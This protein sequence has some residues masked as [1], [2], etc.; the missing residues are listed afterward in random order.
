MLLATDIGNTNISFG[1]FKGNRLK[2]TFDIPTKQYSRNKLF[3]K[4]IPL[5]PADI[6]ISSVVPRM[7]RV[8]TRDL[9]EIAGKKPYIIGKDTKVPIKNLY[10]KPGQV[11][12]DRLV[13][14]YAALKIYGSPLVIIDF[15]TAITFDIISKSGAYEGGL[16]L[17]GLDLSIKALKNGTALLPEI[18]ISRPKELIGKDT[19]SSMLSGIVYG[20]ATMA[21]QLNNKLKKIIGSRA[22]VIATGGNAALIRRYCNNIDRLDNTLTLKGLNLIYKN[23]G[24]L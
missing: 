12:Q 9:A 22:K 7:T 15:G 2:K 24:R 19:A 1:I 13:N 20:F 4:I 17:P 21:E 23:F 16:I 14:A 5:K 3:K 11:G 6:I 8:I 18:K 10:R